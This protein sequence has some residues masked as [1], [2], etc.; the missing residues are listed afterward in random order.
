MKKMPLHWEWFSKSIYLHRHMYAYLHACACWC[1]KSKKQ[2]LEFLEL[3]LLAVVTCSMFWELHLDSLHSE[4]FN[5]WATS[6]SSWV[7]FKYEKLVIFIKLFLYRSD[8]QKCGSSSFRIFSHIHFDN[9]HLL[10]ILN[11]SIPVKELPFWMRFYHILIHSFL[12]H[13]KNV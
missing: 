8:Q 2:V 4:C 1:P 6:A 12:L 9:S 3:E 10:N 5:H 11:H 7:C 13:C